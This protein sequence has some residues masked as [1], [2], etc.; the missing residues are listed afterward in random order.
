MSEF[1]T[2]WPDGVPVQVHGMDADPWF[3]EDDGDLGAARALVASTP[4]AELF[5]YSGE[6][7]LFADDS[8]PAYDEAAAR[9]LTERVLQFLARLS[10]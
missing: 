7:H 3:A 5:L 1:G 9:L 2:A 6:A 8:L 4:E 10:G